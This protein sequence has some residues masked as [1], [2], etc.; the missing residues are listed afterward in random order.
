MSN[1]EPTPAQQLYST[2]TA[3]DM[4]NPH[5]WRSAVWSIV[6]ANWRKAP[7]VLRAQRE[8][9]EALRAEITDRQWRA[10]EAF[11]GEAE[12][13]AVEAA[14]LLGFALAR[15]WPERIADL[16]DWPA[17]AWSYAQLSESVAT[18][19][20]WKAAHAGTLPMVPV[21]PA[22]EEAAPP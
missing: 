18:L 14:A 13:A 9:R 8:R 2:F 20:Q 19:D 21:P 11:V 15:T 10:P 4:L 6:A 12:N 7:A 17:R 22:V 16:A 3:W 1:E 5:D